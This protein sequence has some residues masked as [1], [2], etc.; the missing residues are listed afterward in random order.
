MQDF[1]TI[2]GIVMKV[3]PIGEYDRRIVILTKERGKISAFA[4]GARR[5]SSTLVAATNPF[6]FGEFKLYVGKTSYNVL[7]ANISNYFEALR[8]DF[9]GAYYGMYFLEIADYYARENNDERELLKLVYQS[10]RAIVLPRIPNELIR[11]IYEIK[12]IA[13]NGEFPGIPVDK[14][15]LES[16]EYTIQYIANTNIEHLYNFTVTQEVLEEL[17]HIANLYRR[18]LWDKNFK[19]LEIIEQVRYNNRHV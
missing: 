19:S 14:H 1:L 4:K 9:E 15:Y 18:K 7:E 5:P 8:T 17:H 16:T 6:S 13:V 12:A 2:T 3:V 10:L 11:Y